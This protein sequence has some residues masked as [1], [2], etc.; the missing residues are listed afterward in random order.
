[1]IKTHYIKGKNIYLREVHELDVNDNYYYW[2]NDPEINQYMETRFFPQSKTSILQYVRDHTGNSNE[3]FFA[4]CL[5]DNDLH[6]GNCKLG[7]IN[8]INRRAEISMFIGEKSYWRRGLGTEIIGLIVRYGFETLG[9]HR[10]TSGVIDTNEG[11]KRMFENN[12]F[13]KEGVLKDH[14]YCSDTWHDCYIFGITRPQYDQYLQK[15]IV[16]NK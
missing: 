2:M 15:Q 3:V 7:A 14:A 12:G 11:S 4:S 8:W 16:I 10:L 9:L 1:M 13:T 5:L 6:I